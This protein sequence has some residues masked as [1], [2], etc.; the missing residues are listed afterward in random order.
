MYVLVK[1]KTVVKYPYSIGELKQDNPQ[2]S[3]PATIPDSVLAEYGVYPV[4]PADRPEVDH[5]KNVVE[6]VP[7]LIKGQWYQDFKVVDATP[8]EIQE[9]VDAEIARK[10]T[11]RLEAYRN[12]SDPLFFK[13][14]RGEATEQE[15]KD[16][17][18]EIKERY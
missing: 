15:W 16:K 5:T 6:E 13:W 11:L 7:N 18:A 14:Q 3:F 1:D 17:I 2:T 9:R 12:E 8:E 4:I 10:E